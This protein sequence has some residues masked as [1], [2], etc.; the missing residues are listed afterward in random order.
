[1]AEVLGEDGSNGVDGG[2]S[3]NGEGKVHLGG[4]K[5]RCLRQLGLQSVERLL[6]AIRPDERYAFA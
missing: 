5:Y 4:L 6:G 2:V 1:M 3:Y